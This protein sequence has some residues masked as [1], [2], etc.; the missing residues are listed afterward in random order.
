MGASAVT[1][2]NRAVKKAEVARAFI[3]AIESAKQRSMRDAASK[4][5]NEA[6]REIVA[7]LANRIRH[8]R[9]VPGHE[10]IIEELS[11]VKA[12]VNRGFGN[13]EG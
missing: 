11:A 8:Y 4:G 10:A 13:Y 3:S 5:W 12:A 7:Y 6:H 1:W 2:P 9:T